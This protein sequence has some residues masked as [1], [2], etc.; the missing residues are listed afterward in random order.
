MQPILRSSR[1]KSKWANPAGSSGA[2]WLQCHTFRIERSGSHRLDRP[3]PVSGV[4]WLI[5]M[6]AMSRRSSRVSAGLGNRQLAPVQLISGRSL[7]PLPSHQP[8]Q[9]IQIDVDRR[10][11][12]SRAE[13]FSQRRSTF[14]CRAFGGSR[15]TRIRPES[16]FTPLAIAARFSSVSVTPG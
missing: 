12:R 5:H 1:A 8:S 2:R 6:L 11:R 16:R 3:R 7:P 9:Y 14:T 10:S 4:I 15:S 13:L